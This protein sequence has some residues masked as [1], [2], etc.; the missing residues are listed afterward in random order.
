MKILSHTELFLERSPVVSLLGPRQTGKT[1]L[2]RAVARGRKVTLFDLENPS[3][4]ARLS[5]PLQ[6]LEP[7]RGLVVI[8]E[9]QRLPKLFEVLRVLADRPRNTAKFLIL[10]SADPRL[11][12]GVSES[13][14]GRVSHEPRLAPRLRSRFLATRP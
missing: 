1:T 10:G 11:V 2:A 14:A 8:D 6:A 9:I 7:L 13:L 5:A 12:R 3:H 4:V